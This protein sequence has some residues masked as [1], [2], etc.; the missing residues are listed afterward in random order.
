V[1]DSKQYRVV[2]VDAKTFDPSAYTWAYVVAPAVPLSEI[3][4]STHFA[5][6]IGSK[7][8]SLLLVVS[9][10]KS[11]P[12]TPSAFD[13]GKWLLIFESS[14]RAVKPQMLGGTTSR[15]T[16]RTPGLPEVAPEL[17]AVN[18]YIFPVVPLT[19]PPERLAE[20]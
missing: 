1:D 4:E 10:P 18:A 14:L 19:H 5:F 13:N 20:R 9:I 16:Q 2:F 3:G 11:R 12:P 8:N 6:V 7:H 15:F 17:L